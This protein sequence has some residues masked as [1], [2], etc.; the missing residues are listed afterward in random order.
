M[1]LR[2]H[3]IYDE[4]GPAV[5]ARNGIGKRN[6][7]RGLSE[8]SMRSSGGTK[9]FQSGDWNTKEIHW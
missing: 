8:W 4:T 1:T 9:T 5:L 2:V 3:D 6:T 7:G